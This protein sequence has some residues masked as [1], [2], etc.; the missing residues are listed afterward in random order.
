MNVGPL[1]T[2]KVL[3]FTIL[4]VLRS[5]IQVLNSKFRKFNSN[6]NIYC[7]YLENNSP[8]LLYL[9][10]KIFCKWD[11]ISYRTEQERIPKIFRQLGTKLE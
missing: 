1:D 8:G 3:T 9:E 2:S 5:L 11:A 6:F 7:S 4:E 10:H